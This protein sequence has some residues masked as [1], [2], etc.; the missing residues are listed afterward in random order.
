[1]LG[2]NLLVIIWGAAVRATGSGA[3][4]GDHWPLCNGQVVPREPEMKT[5]IEL[6]HRLTSG[7]ALLMVVGLIVA[8]RRT[9]P[10][11][12]TSKNG[13]Y[14]RRASY[15]TGVFML[16]EALIGAGIVLFRLVAHNDSLARAVS[17][18]LHLVNTFLLLG[19]LTLTIWWASGRALVR[20]KGQGWRAGLFLVSFLGMAAI[21][22]TGAIAALGDTLFPRES[23]QLSQYLDS[24]FHILLRLR[25]VHPFVAI[26]VGLFLM[27]LAWFHSARSDNHFTRNSATSVFVLVLLQFG[28]GVL[29]VALM[30]P[31]WM[32]L[33]HLGLAN[34]VWIAQVFLAASVLGVEQNSVAL[35]LE[36]EM[37]KLGMA[38]VVKS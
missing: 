13:D 26:A 23:L 2:Y 32:Q 33:T 12:N 11:K 22:T 27:G 35:P 1:M 25:I 17:M 10:A 16:L 7:L 15:V 34:L 36:K 6:S 9:F 30:A 20:L 24:A 18:S 5:L 4:C 28:V 3:G 19:A 8:A 21:G 31:V 37:A 29:N 38:S 14:A